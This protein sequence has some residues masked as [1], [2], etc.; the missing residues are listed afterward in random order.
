[1]KQRSKEEGRKVTRGWGLQ[2]WVLTDRGICISAAALQRED[3][4]CRGVTRHSGSA[5]GTQPQLIMPN[6][7]ASLP[8]KYDLC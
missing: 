7:F 4:C 3:I 6:R 8:N 1:M 2:L 5:M